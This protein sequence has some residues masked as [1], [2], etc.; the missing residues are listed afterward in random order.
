MS[1]AAVTTL[2]GPDILPAGCVHV[3]PGGVLSR[4]RRTCT[5]HKCDAHCVGR[6]S[7]GDGLVY[8]CADGRP[9]ITSDQR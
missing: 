1:T 5:T 8:W 7:D 9:H 3:R 2:T 4:V 6:R